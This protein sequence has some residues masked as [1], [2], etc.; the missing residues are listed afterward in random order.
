MVGQRFTDKLASLIFPSL[1]L[2]D[3]LC[4]NACCHGVGRNVVGDDG[5]GTDDGPVAYGDTGHHADVVAQPHVVA[6]H[7]RA[8]AVQRAITLM[9]RFIQNEMIEIYDLLN[10]IVGSV[11]LVNNLERKLC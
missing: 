10:I 1:Q 5:I 4:G 7:H 3:H 2:L 9:M 6:Y 8:F 11:Q